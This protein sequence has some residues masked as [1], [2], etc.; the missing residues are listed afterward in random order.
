MLDLLHHDF[1]P[2]E[3]PAPVPFGTVPPTR[4][5]A[6]DCGLCVGDPVRCD[7]ALILT[8]IAGTRASLQIVHVAA[9]A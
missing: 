2:S 3:R 4:R 6:G 5:A 7:C 1:T 8:T 9:T